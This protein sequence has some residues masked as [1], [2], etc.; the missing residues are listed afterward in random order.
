[1]RVA[2]VKHDP[3][4]KAVFDV[5]GKDSERFFASGADVLVVSPSRTTVFKHHESDFEEIVSS[6]GE[7]DLLIVEG[8]KNWQLP[9]ISLFRESF[10][11]S[12]LAVSSAVA[13]SEKMSQYRQ[14]IPANLC[15]YD[16]D[17]IDGVCGWILENA[18]EI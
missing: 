3:K 15:Q 10:D 12:Y 18:K 11:E 6:L 14:N 5:A 13:L 2:V 17:D 16:L 4:D 7:F 8:L 9:R 1:M